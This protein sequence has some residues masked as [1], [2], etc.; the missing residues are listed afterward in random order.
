MAVWARQ[1]LIITGDTIN[2]VTRVTN[3]L[4]D[5]HRRYG[6]GITIRVPC[7]LLL[8]SSGRFALMEKI[9]C[10]SSSAAYYKLNER[11]IPKDLGNSLS[12]VNTIHPPPANLIDLFH[13]IVSFLTSVVSKLTFR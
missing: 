10:S 6:Q 4:G 9:Y 8:A 3:E 7:L 13:L 11:D 2:K 1:E 5:V 12:D